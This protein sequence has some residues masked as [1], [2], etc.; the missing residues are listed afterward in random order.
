[1]REL[2]RAEAHELL[3][4]IFDWIEARRAVRRRL[5]P[6]VEAVAPNDL[7]IAFAK[8]EVNR[9]PEWKRAAGGG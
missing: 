1:M 6:A 8:A 3:D 2:T 4:V 7:D 9:H 5:R